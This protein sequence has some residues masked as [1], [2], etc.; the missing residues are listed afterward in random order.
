MITENDLRAA[1]AKCKG[2]LN[3]TAST[4][5]KLA[6]YYICLHEEMQESQQYSYESA[7]VIEKTVDYYSD[8]EFGCEIYGK[9][10]NEVIKIIDELAETLQIIQPGLYNGLMRKI[11]EL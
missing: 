11:R 6:A 3:P 1:I 9:P 8:S 10:I 2:E 4:C 7:T 5:I